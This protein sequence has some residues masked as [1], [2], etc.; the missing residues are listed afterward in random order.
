MR[1]Y[2][3]KMVLI[4]YGSRYGSTE[5]ISQRIAKILQEKGLEVQLLDLRKVKPKDWFSPEDFDG[6]LVGSGIKMCKWMSEPQE[7][8]KKFRSVL[9]KG[10]KVLGL[11]ISS[12]FAS[13]PENREKAKVDW[14]EKIMDKVGIQ[15]D[16]YEA[17]GGVFD[18]SQSSKMSGMDKRMLKMAA[19]GMSKVFGIQFDENGR[20]DFRDWDQ[21]R[22]FTEKFAE[23]MNA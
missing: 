2:V 12:G 11:F 18:F 8:L 6:V 13:I 15:A 10:K 17:F 9:K 21:I 22:E 19:K 20:N 5:E 16:I 1:V 14:I 4:A 23:K 7:F 3:K